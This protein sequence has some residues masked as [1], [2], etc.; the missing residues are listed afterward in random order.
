VAERCRVL[1]GEELPR[2]RAQGGAAL[3]RA[4]ADELPALRWTRIQVNLADLELARQ[5]FPQCEVVADAG[6]SGGLAADA[7]DGRIRID[8][9]LDTRLGVAWPELVPILVGKLLPGGCDEPAAA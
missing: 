3:F 5:R 7:E 2:L 1:A 8:N 6:I 4:L 9:T